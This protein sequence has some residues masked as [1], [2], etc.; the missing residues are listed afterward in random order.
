MLRH[1]FFRRSALLLAACATLPAAVRAA[2]HASDA[3]GGPWRSL[4]LITDGQIA[5][6]WAH[7]GW[8]Q[9][10]VDRTALR[11]ACDQRGMGVLLYK[12]EKFGDCQIRVVYR[13]EN[14]QSNAGVFVRIDDGISL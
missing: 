8:G 11:T 7:I 4:P 13:C 2:E 6:A 1:D 9:F 14:P 12:P 3:A 5:P 10:V